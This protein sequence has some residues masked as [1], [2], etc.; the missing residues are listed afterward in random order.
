M[1][2]VLLLF[3][4]YGGKQLMLAAAPSAP[5]QSH[6][7]AGGRRMTVTPSLTNSPRKDVRTPPTQSDELDQDEM[8]D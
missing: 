8:G 3:Q 6:P 7:D 4:H 5:F 1:L 2:A